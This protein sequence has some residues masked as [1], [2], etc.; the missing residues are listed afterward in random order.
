MIKI[1]I[2]GISG[3]VGSHVASRAKEKGWKVGG[4]SRS[5]N[6]NPEWYSATDEKGY[7]AAINDFQP[8]IFLDCSAW[9]NV[10]ACETNPEACIQ[11]NS[12]RPGRCSFLANTNGI[13]Y[14]FLSSSYIFPGNKRT[15]CEA[16][17]P[18]PLNW[19]GE[20]KLLA[21][22]LVRFHTN[23]RAVIIRTMGVYGLIPDG[24][25]FLS[26]VIRCCSRG[27]KIQVP[28]DQFGNFTYAGDLADSILKIL[29]KGW[30]GIWHVAGPEP[31]LCRSDIAKTICKLGGWDEGCI[32]PVPTAKLKQKAVRPQF[33]GLN[34]QKVISH[35]IQ[36][37][38]LEQVWPS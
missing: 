10:D 26:Q 25:D 31:E 6:Q 5:G 29:E 19:Y 33:A 36:M 21:E 1:L 32:D 17:N 8:E 9:A 35:G 15:Y 37:R 28:N 12:L 4:I 7:L 38:S 22:R 34:I 23:E 16:D 20:S 30:H 3:L 27:N 13:Q 11:D 18:R 14:V 2:S 24:K